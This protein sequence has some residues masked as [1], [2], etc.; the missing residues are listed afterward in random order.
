MADLYDRHAASL[1]RHALALVRQRSEA[2]DLV[3]SV[4]VKIAGS[5]VE[6]LGV[7]EPA[8]YLHRVLHTTW[9]DACRRTA[10]AQRIAA[11]T[12]PKE[13]RLPPHDT[14]MDVMRALDALPVEQREIVVLHAIEGFSFREAGRL[15][16]VSLFTA[17][18]RY[19]L[20]MGKMRMSLDPVSKVMP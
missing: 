2:E 14:S 10:V 1:F 8:G 20:A 17:A 9:I 7:R 3:H 12:M 18:A 6:L 4:F 5:G 16:G 15:T 19:R 11:G 13:S